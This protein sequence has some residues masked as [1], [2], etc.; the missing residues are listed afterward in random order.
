MNTVYNALKSQ[1]QISGR[2]YR[3]DS[4]VTIS[5]IKTYKKEFKIFVENRVQEIRKNSNPKDWY[6]CESSNNPADLL[7]RKRTI[8]NFKENI[9]W[10]E[11]PNFLK[12]G[13][14]I[15]QEEPIENSI[16]KE[17]LLS[18]IK[19]LVVNKTREDIIDISKFN[20]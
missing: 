16:S 18:E 6:Y 1:I 20:S 2:T 8:E 19:T 12:D 5:W 9:L 11:G 13:N 17:H 15:V 4:M 3:S 14:F 7:T 10:W